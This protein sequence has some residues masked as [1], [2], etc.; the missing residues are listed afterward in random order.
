MKHRISLLFFAFFLLGFFAFTPSVLAEGLCPGGQYD[1]LC[2]VNATDNTTV[3]RN[4]IN[5][6]FVVAVTVALIFLLLGG[7]KWITSGGDKTKVTEARGTLTAAIVGLMI[8]FLSFFI[9]SVVSFAFG[10]KGGSIF[11]IPQLRNE[12]P[13]LPINTTNKGGGT[14]TGTGDASGGKGFTQ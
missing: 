10:I 12:K 8:T 1:A 3:I 2:N 14:S 11:V 7:I 6:L 5:I 4:I 9:I 13:S